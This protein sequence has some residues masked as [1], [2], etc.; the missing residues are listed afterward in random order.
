VRLHHFLPIGFSRRLAHLLLRL[1]A[2]LFCFES[3]FAMLYK[4]I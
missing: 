4:M 3:N 1:L 2:V